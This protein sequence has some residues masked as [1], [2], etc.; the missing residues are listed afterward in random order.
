MSG[1]GEDDRT[2]QAVITGFGAITP[3]GG[4]REATWRSLIAGKPAVGTISAFDPS[5]LPTQIAG[6]VKD[7]DPA[8]LLDTKR[9]RRSARFSQLAIAAGR[10]A[11]ADAGLILDEDLKTRTGVVVNLA[12]AGMGEVEA[13]TRQIAGPEPRR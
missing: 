13:A 12:V 4:D 7:F 2:D 9:L 1:G 5:G 8:A 10:E 11:V 3:A 6:E